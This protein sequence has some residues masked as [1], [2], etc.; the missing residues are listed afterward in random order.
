M[1]PILKTVGV[2][3]CGFLLVLGL[4]SAVQAGTMATDDKKAGQSERTHRQMQ[5]TQTIQGNVK[6]VTGNSYVIEVLD[7]TEMKLHSD[8][9]TVMSDHI[10]PGDRIEAK[11]TEQNH[12]LSILPIFRV[13]PRS[14]E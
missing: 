3:T 5:T 9:S 12:A 2:P 11:I 8:N 7:G 10:Y 13:V 4:S 1:G 6:Q 14:D